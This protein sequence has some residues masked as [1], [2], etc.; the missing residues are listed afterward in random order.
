ML[1]PNKKCLPNKVVKLFTIHGLWP[2][3]NS[4]NSPQVP[5]GAQK[6]NFDQAKIDRQLRKQLRQYWP[7]L[8]H[9]ID[10]IFWA[11]KW[12][13]HGDFSESLLNQ[14]AY[15]RKTLALHMANNITN[16]LA[17]RARKRNFDKAKIDPQLRKQLRQYWPNLEHK[18]DEIFWASKWNNH[19]DFSES[20]LNQDAYLRKTLAL[21]MANNITN[22]LENSNVIPSPT[23]QDAVIRNA[24]KTHVVSERFN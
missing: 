13:N 2:D 1:L 20:L 8:E 11:S 17:N 22:I 21:H 23:P 6:R 5:L 16:I 18:I 10:E 24:V 3:D 4:W 7:N 19:G 9:K 14:D 15:L 12:N